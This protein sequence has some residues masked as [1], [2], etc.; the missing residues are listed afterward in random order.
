MNVTEID[1]SN[2]PIYRRAVDDT[3]HK[4]M[5]SLHDVIRI[6]CSK[7]N[8][9]YDPYM[10]GLGNGLIMAESLITG[11]QPE[12]LSAPRKWGKDYPSFWVK[13]KWKLFPR[14]MTATSPTQQSEANE[15]L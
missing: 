9:D 4:L 6:Q 3:R 1:Y 15:K 12:F 5:E 14:S 8:W 11:R 7:G 13:L 10:M 2:N